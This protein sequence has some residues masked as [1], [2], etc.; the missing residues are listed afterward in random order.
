MCSVNYAF[1]TGTSTVTIKNANKTQKMPLLIATIGQDNNQLEGFADYLKLILDRKNQNTS[2]FLVTVKSLKKIPSKREFKIFFKEKF[3]LV[4]LMTYAKEGQV[5]WRMYDTQHA[6]MVAGKRFAHNNLPACAQAEHLADQIWPVLTGQE[7]FFTTRIAFCKEVPDGKR[8]KKN[9]S[10]VAPYADP[11]TTIYKEL[12]TDLVNQGNTFAPRWNKEANNPLVLYSQSTLSNVRLMSVD[13]HKNSRVVSN[14]KGL[15]IL[16]SFS[17]DGKKVVYCLSRNGK[18]QLYLYEFDA[19]LGKPVLNQITFNKGNNICPT[20]R[21]NGDIVFCSDFKART[22]QVCYYHAFTKQVDVLTTDGY[23][24]C[25]TFCEK[26]GKIAYSKFIDGVMQLC[27]YDLK[28]RCITQITFDRGN[29]EECTWS[30]CGN[31][32]AFVVDS[33]SVTRIALLNLITQERSFLTASNERCSYPC[34]SPN[35]A[36]PLIIS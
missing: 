33:G 32:L 12:R 34:W 35:Y 1:L 30:P 23:S 16:P 31:Y 21:D 26:S 25:P 24:A 9:I 5:E 2:G 3:P 7:G 36:V 28:S 17:G 20:L 4:V 22:P 27:T 14:F 19:Q 10:L 8:V 29:K 18:S 13:M 11:L 15:N 6:S